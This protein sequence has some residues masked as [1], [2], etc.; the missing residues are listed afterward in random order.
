MKERVY[1]TKEDKNILLKAQK[2]LLK[3]NK[4]PSLSIKCLIGFPK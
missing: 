4:Y 2:I 1:L 3:Y